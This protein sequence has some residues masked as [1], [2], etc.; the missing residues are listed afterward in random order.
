MTDIID[1]DSIPTDNDTVVFDLRVRCDRRPD[2]KNETD[3]KLR[4]Y[5]SNVY[6]GMLEWAPTESQKLKHANDPCRPVQPD[7]LLN[8]LRPGQVR[9]TLLKVP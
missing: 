3:P 2:G 7:I 8:K 9:P 6:S 1:F 5:D 4:Y